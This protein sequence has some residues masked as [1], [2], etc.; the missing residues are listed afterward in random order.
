MSTD[1]VQYHKQWRQQKKQTVA[2]LQESVDTLTA[3]LKRFLPLLELSDE[4]LLKII[5]EYTHVD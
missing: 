1:R 3:E 4:Q 5:E 2:S